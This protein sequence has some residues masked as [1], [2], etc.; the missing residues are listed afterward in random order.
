MSDST[1]KQKVKEF[2]SPGQ[3]AKQYPGLTPGLLQ[4]MRENGKGPTYLQPTGERGRVLYERADLELWIYRN[5][6]GTSIRLE[7][8]PE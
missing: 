5:K 3:V 2:L 8:I 6:K 1:N 4:T 7:D